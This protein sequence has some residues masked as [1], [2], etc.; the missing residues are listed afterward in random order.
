MN[1]Q[2]HTQKEREREKGGA[3]RERLGSAFEGAPPPPAPRVYSE[4]L[5]ILYL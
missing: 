4:D 5:V 1:T 3:E 2:T